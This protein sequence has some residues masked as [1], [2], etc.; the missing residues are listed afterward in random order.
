V[1]DIPPQ[2]KPVGA[3]KFDKIHSVAF[4]RAG[5]SYK[6]GE[7][8]GIKEISFSASSGKTIALVGP[9]GSG[10]TTLI[11]LLV[12]LYEPSAGK[13]SFNGID[14]KQIDYDDLRKKIGLVSQETQLFAGSIR[15]NLL[16]VRPEATDEECLKVLKDA[17]VS[18]I[19][20]RGDKGLD[21]VI[22]EGGLKLSGGERQRLAIARALLRRPD[23]LIFDEA[24]SSLD[25]LTE[26]GIIQ[27]I[28]SIEQKS[29]ELIII[30]ISHR[31]S[32]VAHADVIYVLKEGKI[33]EAGNH[34]ELLALGG[35]YC[36]LW[37]EQSSDG[38]N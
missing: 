8:S 28:K 35:L 5:F 2:P 24:T 3:V 13:I 26:K 14:E 38:T 36:A 21:T 9:S 18:G 6:S 31:L 7:E 22:G 25:S 32:T 29:A 10:K 27:T 33:T 1:L 16:F 11:K 17:A 23:M 20:D 30:L 15:D 34:P 12:G 4:E 37:H 19:V